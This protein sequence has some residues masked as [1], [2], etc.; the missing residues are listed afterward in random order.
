MY[1]SYNDDTGKPPTIYRSPA[2]IRRDIQYIS[3]R[4]K[5]TNEKL[6]VRGILVDILMSERADFPEKLVLDLEE[7]LNE[8]RE[9]LMQLTELNAELSDLR[10]ELDEVRCALGS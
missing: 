7:A 3:V 5:E 6:N 2:D 4:I 8:A 1:R 9:A 10:E